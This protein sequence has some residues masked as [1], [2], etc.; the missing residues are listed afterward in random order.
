MDKE[1]IKGLIAEYQQF[2]KGV[3]FVKRAEVLSNVSA[4]TSS[5]RDR[6]L[7]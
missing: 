7:T 3:S 6:Y 2:V 1:L 5:D 4:D